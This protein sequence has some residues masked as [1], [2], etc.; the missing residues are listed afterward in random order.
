MEISAEVIPFLEG[1]ANR[2]QG[3][4]MIHR[5]GVSGPSR[6]I[7]PLEF[8]VFSFMG[9][10]GVL[11]LSLDFFVAMGIRDIADGDRLGL[12][13]ACGRGRESGS[14][15]LGRRNLGDECWRQGRL[16]WSRVSQF[17]RAT[18]L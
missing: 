1:Q 12:W 2:G 15:E 17:R 4:G 11:F 10:R 16:L 3:G 5:L 6:R 7:S 8:A 14:L 18:A 9:W 13:T